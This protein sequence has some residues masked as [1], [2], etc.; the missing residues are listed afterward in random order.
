MLEIQ[1]VNCLNCNSEYNPNDE[2]HIE[3]CEECGTV[4]CPH[5]ERYGAMLS[6]IVLCRGCSREYSIMYGG[7]C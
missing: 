7:E 4:L 3:Y 1:V 2:E 6:E 5:C